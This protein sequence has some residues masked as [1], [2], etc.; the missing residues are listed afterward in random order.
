[1]PDRLPTPG[2]GGRSTP[3]TL[4]M[5]PGRFAALVSRLAFG[6]FLVVVWAIRPFPRTL[7]GGLSVAV[8]GLTN[9]ASGAT[10]AQF[11]MANAF[12]HSVR[13]LVGDVEVLQTNGWPNVIV[14]TSG[15]GFERSRPARSHLVFSLPVPTEQGATCGFHSVIRR[16]VGES[17]LGSKP[18]NVPFTTC[19]VGRVPSFAGSRGRSQIAWR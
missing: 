6:L 8:V 10:L 16:T 9:D 11:T 13:F 18:S 1:M 2:S 3:L 12:S 15:Y 4:G 7:I 14:N 5:T 17:R 19:V